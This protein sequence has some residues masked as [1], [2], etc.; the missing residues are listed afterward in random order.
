MGVHSRTHGGKGVDG[1]EDNFNVCFRGVEKTAQAHMKDYDLKEL[2]RQCLLN[3]TINPGA[4]RFVL[5]SD[6]VLDWS[7]FGDQAVVVSNALPENV[8]TT[9]GKKDWTVVAALAELFSL[10]SVDYFYGNMYSTFSLSVCML[11]GEARVRDS[12]ICW[13]VMHPDERYATP[14]K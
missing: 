5:A 4:G 14:I 10:V 3:E 9:L 12:S 2:Q 7:K 1:G 8:K 11:R 6:G 13:M